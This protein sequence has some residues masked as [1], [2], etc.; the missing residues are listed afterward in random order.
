MLNLNLSHKPPS[1]CRIL[2]LSGGRARQFSCLKKF[3]SLVVTGEGF[4]KRIII[5]GSQMPSGLPLIDQSL[6]RIKVDVTGLS[7]HAPS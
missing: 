6:L 2:F 1:S 5:Q 4:L 7:G 3:R